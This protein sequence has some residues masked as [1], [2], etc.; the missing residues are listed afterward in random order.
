MGHKKARDI[1]KKQRRKLKLE[2]LAEEGVAFCMKHQAYLPPHVIIAK[3][4]YT[5]KKNNGY[6][7]YMVERDE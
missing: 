6:C 7:K 3:R 4:C 2:V 5:N 1:E